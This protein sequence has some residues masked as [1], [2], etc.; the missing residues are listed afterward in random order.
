MIDQSTHLFFW[1]DNDERNLKRLSGISW[2]SAKTVQGLIMNLDR[3]Q[4]L[5][6]NTRTGEMARITPPP[7]DEVSTGR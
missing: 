4:V 2:K 7:P 1:L 6:I 5:Y 3:Y